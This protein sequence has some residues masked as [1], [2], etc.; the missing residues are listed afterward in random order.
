ME[1]ECYENSSLFQVQSRDRILYGAR[2]H[3]EPLILYILKS[4]QSEIVGSMISIENISNLFHDTNLMQ[5]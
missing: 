3:N 2:S 1:C 5:V 4:K